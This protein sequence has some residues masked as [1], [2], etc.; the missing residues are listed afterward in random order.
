MLFVKYYY[1]AIFNQFSNPEVPA[2]SKKFEKMILFIK[3]V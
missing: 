1:N 3:A 2:F